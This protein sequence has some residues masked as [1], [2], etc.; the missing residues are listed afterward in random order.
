MTAQ[1]TNCGQT[2][3]TY[4][5]QTTY[6]QV[7]LWM[8]HQLTKQVAASL[9]AG[10]AVS[11]VTAVIL[12]ATGI[13]AVP[14]VVPEIISIALTAFIGEIEVYDDGCGVEITYKRYYVGGTTGSIHSQ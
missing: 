1:A 7:N 3:L 11:A 4:S 12:D 2:K 10:D 5:I 9:I 14:A 13:G 8:D 6:A